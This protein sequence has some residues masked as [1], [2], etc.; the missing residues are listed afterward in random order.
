MFQCVVCVSRLS[1]FVSSHLRIS[2]QE[3]LEKAGEYFKSKEGTIEWPKTKRLKLGDEAS[4]KSETSN[5]PSSLQLVDIG[6]E[7]L[8]VFPDNS[9]SG[10]NGVYDTK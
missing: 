5:G 4:V 7:K 1:S 9:M 8:I 2:L 10:S 3:C 6:K